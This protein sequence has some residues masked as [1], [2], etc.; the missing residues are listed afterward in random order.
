[1]KLTRRLP[2]CGWDKAR[3]RGSL[4]RRAR[5]EHSNEPPASTASGFIPV[6]RCPEPAEIHRPINYH[7]SIDNFKNIA[8]PSIF[9]FYG[10]ELLKQLK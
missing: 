3:A 8:L 7:I 4:L 6:R 9:H 10:L 2:F 1:M 5:T